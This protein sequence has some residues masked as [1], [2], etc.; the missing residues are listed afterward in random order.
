MRAFGARHGWRA[1]LAGD[2]LIVGT[3]LALGA[4]LQWN[5]TAGNYVDLERAWPAWRIAESLLWATVMLLLIS[6][7]MHVKP[8]FANRAFAYV[9]V[10]SYSIYLL[11]TPVLLY[12]RAVIREWFPGT[13]AGW[14]PASA[15]V[16]FVLA[17]IV[18]TLATITYRLIERPAMRRK[19]RVPLWAPTRGGSVPT[20]AI[21]GPLAGA[22]LHHAPPRSEPL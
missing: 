15:T 14:A 6:V 11:H 21:A 10:T 16:V 18:L 22:R 19:L 12:G 20:P 17:C 13:L 1:R 9:G 7:P 3:V 5:V 4:L 2:V 8:L